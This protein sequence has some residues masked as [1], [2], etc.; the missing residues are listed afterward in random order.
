VIST[1]LR[2]GVAAGAAGVTA[3]NA[4]TYL[5][6]ALRGRAASDAPEQTVEALT[7]AL[8]AHIPGGGD[9]RRSRRTALGA[10][11][12]IGTGIAV[13]VAASTARAAGFTLPA[14]VGVLVTGAAAMAASDVPMAAL[15]VSD[16]RGWAPSAWLSDVVPHLAYGLVTR[17]VVHSQPTE[18]ERQ[19]L[20]SPSRRASAGLLLR[21]AAL[22]VAAGARSSLGLSA[23]ALTGSVGGA[24]SSGAALMVGGEL[25]ADKLPATPSRLQPPALALR[26]LSGAGGAVT[27]AHREHAEPTWP[28]LLGA[29][30]AAAGSWSGAAW[31]GW[32]KEQMPDWQAALL[33]DA[34]ALALATVACLPH[35]AG[36][37][38]RPTYAAL[39]NA[40]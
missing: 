23:P 7:K 4:V 19:R 8:G 28:T 10:L 1:V 17:V 14:P 36:S 11:S 2:R 25:V 34:V 22:G 24:V 37:S 21:S 5:N 32:A 9:V 33:E 38:D 26:V 3:L 20:Q 27:L 29:A 31:R 13:G 12:G 15:G 35:R 40:H 30:G 18:A 6:M 39:V 16:P